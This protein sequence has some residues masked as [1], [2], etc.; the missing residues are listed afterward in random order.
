MWRF[1]PALDA[2]RH[3]RGSDLRA[4]FLAGLTVAAVAVPQAMAY[5]LVAG[6]DPAVG[7]YSAIVITAVGAI[8]DSSRQLIN[9]PTNATSIAILSATSAIAADDKLGAVLLLGFLIG[10]IQLGITFLR[11]GDLTRYVSHSV[12]V[13]FTAGAGT[14]LVLDQLK[15]LLGTRALV[16]PDEHFLVRV[17]ASLTAGG[18][19]H[20]PTLAIGLATVVLAIGLRWLKLRLNTAL[21]PEFLFIMVGMAAVTGLAGLDTAGVAVVGA[22]PASLPT[23][24]APE[25]D[26]GRMRDLSSSAFA[27]AVLGLLEALAMAKAIAART[28]QRLDLN[29]QCL[30]EGV[31]N[32]TGSFFHALPGSGSLT[33][34]AI[35]VQAGAR[36]QWSGIW[37][38]AAVALIILLL[39]PWAR[40]IPRA[41]LAGLL[42]VTAWRMVDKEALLYSVRATRFDAVI[43]GATAFAA[44]FV[45]VEFCIVVGVMLSF[46][47]AVPRSGRMQL[48]EFVVGE[49][50]FVHER[51]GDDDA[52]PRLLIFG[53]EGEMFF[54]AGPSL[55]AHFDTIEGRVT[56]ET[57]VVLLRVKRARTPDAVGTHMLDE[58]V[59]R[60]H[61]RGLNVLLCGVRGDLFQVFERTGL[62]ALLGEDHVFV[63]H[64]IRQTSTAKAVA[65][66]QALL[67]R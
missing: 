27:I 9:G 33:R 67:L 28:G 25:F 45:S 20:L 40:F 30:A 26:L 8:F 7:L 58:F 18:P 48:S 11:L 2:L 44:V 36:T 64:P 24:G 16:S 3:Y 10:S 65:H 57:R 55:E 12:I 21:F 51:F 29:Q 19:V 14:L 62:L 35:N 54:A 4:D 15:N 66:A 56:R 1:F 60:L 63:E 6:V 47:L 41:A 5:A 53:L 38:A 59:R 13:G 34:S 32:V 46:L 23:F 43:V 50:G 49:D 39:A 17:W 37:S 42:I 61:A 22:I 31:A 52:D